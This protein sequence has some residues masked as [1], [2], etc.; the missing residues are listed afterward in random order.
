MKLG[1]N[2]CK[3]Y[4]LW[5]LHLHKLS[6]SLPVENDKFAISDIGLLRAVWNNFKN[7]L[8]I[9]GTLVNLLML[10]SFITDGTSSVFVGDIKKELVFGFFI[11]L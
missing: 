9:L 11:Y 2:Y 4:G 8:G 5:E 10:D 1:D 6:G 3:W 7:L